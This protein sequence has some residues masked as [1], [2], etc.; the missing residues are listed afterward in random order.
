MKLWRND[1]I[2]FVMDN[3]S[4]GDYPE[5]ELDYWQEEALLA[6]QS[7]DKDRIRIALQACAGVGKSAVL[8]WAGWW[9]LGCLGDKGEHP[10]GA[11][12]S[13][14]EANLRDNLWTEFSKWQQRSPYLS[15]AFTWT[16]KKIYANDHPETW[17]LSA[18]S[19]PQSADRETIGK[20]LSGIHG[21]Y[22]LFLIDESGAIPIEIKKATE[23]AVGEAL[24][25]GGFI[26]ILQAGNPL[27]VTGL[28]YASVK[29]KNTHVIRITGDPHDPKRSSRINKE[30]AIEQI[31][32]YGR[33]DPWVMAYI[34]G[35]FPTTG[36]DSLLSID[37]VLD[38]MNRVVDPS[39]IEPYQKRLGIDVAREGL[40]STIIF[41]RQGKVAFR[42]KELRG[43]KGDE[44]ATTVNIAKRKFE[45]EVEFIDGTGGFGGSVADFLRLSGNNPI[46]VHFASSASDSRFF[47]KR[48][49]MFFNLCEW[50]KGGG[51]LPKCDILKEELLTIKAVFHNGKTRII[52]K[53]QMKKV[54]GKSPDRIDSLALTF[55]Q[56]DIP[57]SK[58]SNHGGLSHKSNIKG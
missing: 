9:F 35:M 48:T 30:W 45:S 50:I 31:E 8:A 43:A 26:K 22:V 4:G 3:F 57:R 28:L 21:K 11:A 29:S 38:A 2:Q 24:E 34:L 23:Q 47:N 42:Y 20:T 41:P 46:E 19:F 40:D 10:K 39:V 49:E 36:V 14:S 16:A 53:D 27:T 18:R 6:F 12:L 44:V 55:A 54:L 13:I 51:C 15:H 52:S 5:I 37:E 17:F 7:R 33:T 56:P 32:T 25:S 58:Y 1:I